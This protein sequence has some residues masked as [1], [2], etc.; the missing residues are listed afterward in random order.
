M[1]LRL[2]KKIETSLIF[3]PEYIT[4][5]TVARVVLQMFTTLA[6]RITL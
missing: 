6:M 1:D 5:T 3:H 4:R 2:T